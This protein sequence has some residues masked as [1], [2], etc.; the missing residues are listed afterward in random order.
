M[1]GTSSCRSSLST[2][3]LHF[4][5]CLRD[6]RAVQHVPSIDN[7]PTWA[8]G[9]IA[10]FA[11]AAITVQREGT[12]NVISFD[13][14][15]EVGSAAEFISSIEKV[16]GE[17]LLLKPSSTSAFTART[18]EPFP[19]GIYTFLPKSGKVLHDADLVRRVDEAE[20]RIAEQRIHQDDAEAR[21]AELSIQQNRG[22]QTTQTAQKLGAVWMKRAHKTAPYTIPDLTGRVFAKKRKRGETADSDVYAPNHLSGLTL[23]DLIPMSMEVERCRASSLRG[24]QA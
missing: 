19:H 12:G 7:V 8:I 5:V 11:M 20:A 24:L 10:R 22:S 16:W 15:A 18:P 3:R 1:S 2:D 23:A 9:C 14:V 13:T 21:I 17:G 6:Q 4:R